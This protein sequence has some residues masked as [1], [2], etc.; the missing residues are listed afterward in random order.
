MK[1]IDK[2]IIS[3]DSHITEPGDLYVS[4]VSQKYREKAPKLVTADTGG[5]VFVIDGLD[6]FLFPI[7][8]CSGAGFRGKEI[9]E[10]AN[11]KLSDCYA[12]GWDSRQ[13]LLDQDH[14]GI[15]G[16]VIYPSLGMLLCNHP[17]GSWKSEMFRAYNDW[18]AEYCEIAPNRLIGLGQTPMNTPEEG[19]RDLEAMKKLGLK[20]VMMPG[21]PALEDYDSPIYDDFYSAAEEL[22]MPLSFHILTYKDGL[23][24]ARGPKV[25]S[26]M[27][28]IRGNQDILGMMVFS[29]V[30]QRHPKLKVVCAEA[31]AGWVPHYMYRMDYAA[32]RNP[33]TA[34][35]KML[36]Q[37][38]SYYFRNNVYLTF[39]DDAIA[40]QLRDY[41][42]KERMLWAS[43]FPHLDSTYPWSQSLLAE[44]TAGMTKPELEMLLHDNVAGLYQLN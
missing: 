4:R 32:E 36:E 12:G 20:G 21:H 31:D 24:R 26:F 14:D 35:Q 27:S 28:L 11:A 19:I 5:D 8:L 22:G 1:L 23:G 37:S 30:F 10:R 15:G 42:N 16:E 33:W 44:Q 43:D 17:D 40:L 9:K 7:T 2:P 41:F 34:G 38:P 39:Q 6:D 18:M 13:R 29:G 3:A 25:N